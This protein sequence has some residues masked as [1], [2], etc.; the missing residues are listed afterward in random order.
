MHWI[1]SKMA[2]LVA[3]VSA[4]LVLAACGGGGSDTSTKITYT[5]LVSFGDSL[6]DVG[7]YKVGAIAAVGGG[8]WTV[9]GT[10]TGPVNWT[11]LLAGQINVAAPCPAQTGL[12]SNV[13]QIPLVP[14]VANANCTNYAQGS[15]RV[16]LPFGPN[17]VAL[18]PYITPDTNIGLMAVPLVTQFTTQLAAHGNY[19]GKELVTVMAGANDIFMHANAVAAAAAGG[20]AAAGAATLAG[21]SSAEVNAVAA[22]GAAAVNAAA[23]AAVTHSALNAAALA[24]AIKD[25]VT[26]KGAKYVVVVNV[27]SIEYTPFGQT[28]GATDLLRAMVTTFNSTLKNDLLYT[29]GLLLVDAY[30]Q[31]IAQYNNPAQYGITNV[32]VPACSSAAPS[33]SNPAGNILLGSSLA[34]TVNNTLSGVDVSNYLYADGVHP[35]PAG[36]KLLNRYVAEQMAKAGWL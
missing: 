10:T 28:S 19:T 6:S 27:P 12:L 18:Q 3:S 31:G 23:T 14:V 16:E 36:Y 30:T 35:T 1:P 13:A 9:N 24:K 22:G 32:K 5:S 15:S 25:S 21:W 17:A 34:C 4:A 20:A 8:K 11:E 29:P 26:G 33:A 7:T 2:L